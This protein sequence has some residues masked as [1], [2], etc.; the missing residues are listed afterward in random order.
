MAAKVI[1]DEVVRDSEGN[2]S[3][4]FRIPDMEKLLYSVPFIV[5]TNSYLSNIYTPL[6]WNIVNII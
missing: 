6:R 5:V 1:V 4:Y 3:S 2:K